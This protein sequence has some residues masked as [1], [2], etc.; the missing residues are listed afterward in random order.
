M[1]KT[2][3][4]TFSRIFSKI[5]KEILN[6]TFATELKQ[7]G[8][9]L[10][11]L[12]IKHVIKGIVLPEIGATVGKETVVYILPEY[13]MVIKDV[14][15]YNNLMTG[16]LYKIP[17]HARENK[18]I[19]TVIQGAY[20]MPFAG[21]GDLFPS[22][23]NRSG[24]SVSTLTD[25]VLESHT[26]SGANTSPH[27]ELRE[28]NIIQVYPRIMVMP[29]ALSCRLGYNEDFLNLPEGTIEP[30]ARYI[31]TALKGY[32][33]HKLAIPLSS[34]S[35]MSGVSLGVIQDMVNKYEDEG[36]D[37]KMRE[38]LDRVRGGSLLS[39]ESI[40]KFAALAM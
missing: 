28:D 16:T 10:D 31:V 5:P 11:E 20:R 29:L 8:I 6:L 38:D 9:T 40:T 39:P 22:N 24:N 17:S 14:Y 15:P 35:L 26:F 2:L 18:E 30:M 13:E 27:V 3:E 4:I 23:I 7:V 19:I 36:G 37:E 25:Q 21:N 34:G 33:Y 32:I 12:I 1:S